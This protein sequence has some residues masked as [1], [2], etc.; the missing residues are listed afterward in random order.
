M[1]AWS[2]LVYGNGLENRRFWKGSVSSNLTASTKQGDV[3]HQVEQQTEN[4]CV[5]GSSPIF[6]TKIYTQL[7]QW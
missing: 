5:V 2:S 4:L 3:A 6:G 7:A 1:E